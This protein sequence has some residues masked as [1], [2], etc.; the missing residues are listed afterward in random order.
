MQ[1]HFGHDSYVRKAKAQCRIVTLARLIGS[2]DWMRFMHVFDSLERSMWHLVYG[3]TQIGYAHSVTSQA[4]ASAI[5]INTDSGA[6]FYL[7]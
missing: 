7:S 4:L 2:A 6:N 5:H 1:L 3:E